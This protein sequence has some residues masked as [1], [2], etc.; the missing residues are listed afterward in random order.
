MEARKQ[1][2]GLLICDEGEVSQEDMDKLKK[3]YDKVFLPPVLLAET[4]DGSCRIWACG[5]FREE[6]KH[7]GS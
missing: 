5:G 7:E 6:N 3:W 1:R 4:P 2:S